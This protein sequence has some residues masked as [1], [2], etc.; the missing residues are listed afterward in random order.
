MADWKF[1]IY[2]FSFTYST[3]EKLN[4]SIVKQILRL[5]V[6]LISVSIYIII[7]NEHGLFI[8]KEVRVLK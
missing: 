1:C 8:V 7:I 3:Y 5:L 4:P 6:M 2:M